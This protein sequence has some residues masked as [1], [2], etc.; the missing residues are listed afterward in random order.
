MRRI[1]KQVLLD[2]L[3]NRMVLGYCLMLMC[4]SCFSAS[5]NIDSLGIASD[6][7]VAICSLESFPLSQTCLNI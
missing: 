7:S 2:I 3:R 1:V 5:R 4:L 6:C